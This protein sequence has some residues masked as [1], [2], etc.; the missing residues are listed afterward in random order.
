MCTTE[1]G[2]LP[3]GRC[4]I[5]EV[6]G[7][8]TAYDVMKKCNIKWNIENIVDNNIYTTK[9]KF[10]KDDFIHINTSKPLNIIVQLILDITFPL[11]TGVLTYGAFVVVGMLAR[12]M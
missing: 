1:S 6:M 11:T 12:K 3:F 5:E 10:G 7:L 8:I 4:N 9:F 2:A